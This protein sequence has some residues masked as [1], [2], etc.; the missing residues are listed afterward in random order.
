MNDEVPPTTLRPE[1][2][3][4]MRCLVVF[5][6]VVSAW[7]PMSA[8]SAAAPTCQGLP[9]TIVGAPGD[10]VVGTDG[11]DVIVSNGAGTVVGKAG[12]D[13]IC[14]TYQGRRATTRLY[15]GTGDDVVT[16]GSGRDVVQVGVDG[17]PS[18]DPG[19][20][21]I[22]TGR[23]DDRV[24]ITDVEAVHD[25][26]ELGPGDDA[27]RFERGVPVAPDAMVEGG[28]GSD[29]LALAGDERSPGDELVVDNERRVA[30]VDGT[31]THRWSGFEAFNVSNAH[32]TSIVFVGSRIDEQLYVEPLGARLDARMGAGGDNV[33]ID[34]PGAA[35]AAVVGG[36]G[37]D[38][39]TLEYLE[40]AR[41]ELDVSQ[42]AARTKVPDYGDVDFAGIDEYWLSA[43]NAVMFG[44]PRADRFF[45]DADRGLLRGA[46]G[47]DH[48]A[49]WPGSTHS[50]GCG[51]ANFG[52]GRGDDR[53]RGGLADDV[54]DGGAGNDIAF[55]LRGVDRC[56][57][58]ERR[59]GCEG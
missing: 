36:A 2:V 47:A 53:L 41:V 16:G 54:L 43:S 52:G 59:F 14:V 26:I 51:R 20:D 18:P 31:E 25:R 4:V 3:S 1:E 10:T 37:R 56:P 42:G 32:Y 38:V 33:T 29:V 11:P 17:D 13:H 46:D 34:D 39:L 57:D 21:T 58:V 48:L 22:R 8:A 6:L 7:V 55:G 28:P 9:A 44:G 50:R 35:G 12:D 30:E 23:G 24:L 40:H 49:C 45:V 27:V 19:V 5:G 15:P